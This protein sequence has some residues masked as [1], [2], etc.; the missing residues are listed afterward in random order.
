MTVDPQ[1]FA[2]DRLI[3]NFVGQ[4]MYTYYELGRNGAR[5]DAEEDRLKEI[6]NRLDILGIEPGGIMLPPRKKR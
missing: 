6:K 1:L 3:P 5:T 4:D 2:L